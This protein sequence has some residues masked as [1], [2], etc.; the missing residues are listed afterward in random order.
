MTAR[1][2]VV[3]K[4]AA[5]AALVLCLLMFSVPTVDFVYTGF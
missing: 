2:R 3:M 1:W 5:L 4:L